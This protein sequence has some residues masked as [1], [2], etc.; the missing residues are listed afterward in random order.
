MSREDA[1][2]TYRPFVPNSFVIYP[3]VKVDDKIEFV[4][5]DVLE[6]NYPYAFKY[7]MHYQISY[8][9][10]CDHNHRI[11]YHPRKVQFSPTSNPPLQYD[12]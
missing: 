8:T 6:K 9:D 3:Y 11:Q 12:V 10:N 7:L 5:I 2:N 4:E 1:L